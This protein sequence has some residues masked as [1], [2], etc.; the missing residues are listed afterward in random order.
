MKKERSTLIFFVIIVVVLIVLYPQ[1]I[2]QSHRKSDLEVLHNDYISAK[3]YADNELEYQLI[4]QCDPATYSDEREGVIINII[5][6]KYANYV[7][8]RYEYYKNEIN[9]AD[10]SNGY[11]YDSESF[12]YDI[13]QYNPYFD[14]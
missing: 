1:I 14:E 7:N 11:R 13:N 10:Y 9:N 4:F 6:Q 2:I 12:I 3:N 8:K 5:V